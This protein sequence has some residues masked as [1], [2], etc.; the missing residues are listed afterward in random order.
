VHVVATHSHFGIELYVGMTTQPCTRA[1]AMTT[2]TVLIVTT[3]TVLMVPFI[4]LG[5]A[6]TARRAASGAGGRVPSA[7]DPGHSHRRGFRRH[8]QRLS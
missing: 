2:P 5:L 7:V 6:Q 3:P 1:R 8:S 4:R